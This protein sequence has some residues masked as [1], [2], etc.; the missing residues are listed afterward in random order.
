VRQPDSRRRVAKKNDIFV[1]NFLPGLTSPNGGT[2]SDIT[3][4]ATLGCAC[5]GELAQ[6]STLQQHQFWY[7]FK[8]NFYDLTMPAKDICWI[9][10][11]D[12]DASVKKHQSSQL[13][14][15]TLLPNI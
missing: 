10:H 8:A 3:T 14:M 15:D 12:W 1:I 4:A 11:H 2:T 5:A 9:G 7:M 6:Y 13:N